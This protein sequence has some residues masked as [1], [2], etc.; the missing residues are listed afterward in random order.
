[1]TGPTSSRLAT[2]KLGRPAFRSASTICSRRLLEARAL[3][4]GLALRQA[5]RAIVRSAASPYC[6]STLSPGIAS[7][8]WRTCVLADG[9]IEPDDDERAAGEVDAERQAAACTIMATPATMTTQRQGDGVPAPAE[10]V[11][12]RVGQKSA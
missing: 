6:W 4:R 11:V 9:L 10:E 12:V 1:M 8:A 5:D 3:L 2:S 7:S